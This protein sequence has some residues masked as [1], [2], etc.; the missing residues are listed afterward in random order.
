MGRGEE[1]GQGTEWEF[2]FIFYFFFFGGFPKVYGQ[3]GWADVQQVEQAQL[4]G[5]PTVTEDL[6][7]VPLSSL[8]KLGLE[9]LLLVCF[10]LGD[11]AGADEEHQQAE[12][13]RKVCEAHEKADDE[14]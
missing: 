11:L 4:Q 6:Q 10:E 9:P 13:E 2:P 7:P 3:V 12:E 5:H 14:S 8:L 1:V